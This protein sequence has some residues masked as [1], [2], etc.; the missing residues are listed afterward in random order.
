M[1]TVAMGL[2]GPGEFGSVEER[3]GGGKV[4]QGEFGGGK[5]TFGTDFDCLGEH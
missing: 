4:V 1:N 2:G 3:G 5:T